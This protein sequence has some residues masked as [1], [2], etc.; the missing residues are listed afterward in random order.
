[1]KSYDKNIESSYL[2]HLDANNL[3]GC[4]MSQKLPVNGC[5]WE[6][7][8]SK[9]DEDFLTNYDEDSNKGDILEVGVEYPKQILNLHIDLPSL[10]EK[11]TIKRCN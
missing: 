10:S 1:M 4:A 9:F 11:M 8:L 3:Y 5:K 7:N 2:M 6:K